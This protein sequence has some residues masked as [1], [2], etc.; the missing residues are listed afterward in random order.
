VEILRLACGRCKGTLT[1][2]PIQQA[3]VQ[4]GKDREMKTV[5]IAVADVRKDLPSSSKMYLDLQVIT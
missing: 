5:S 4:I 2:C 1:V 3:F